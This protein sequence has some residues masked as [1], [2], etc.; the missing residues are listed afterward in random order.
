MTPQDLLAAFET[1]ADAPNGVTRLRELVLQLAVRG[2]L[3]PQD[4]TDEP[5]VALMARIAAQRTATGGRA[6]ARRPIAP[7]E[8]PFEIPATWQWVPFGEIFECRLG[9]MLDK[10][11]NRGAL[12]P[13][14]RNANVRWRGFDLSDVLTMRLTAEELPDVTVKKGDLVICEG[15]EPGRAA[16]WASEE[17]FAIQKA[18]HRARPC[19]VD[20]RYY[21]IHLRVD[22]SSGRLAE[23]F[24]GATIKHL[25]GQ[26]LDKYSVTLPPLKE[27]HRIVARVGELMGLLDRLEAARI[28][29][30]NVRRAARGAALAA[31]RDAGDVEAVEAAWGRI[32]GQVGLLI[33]DPSDVGAFR[34]AVVQLAVGGRLV[35]QDPSDSP[36]AK[37]LASIR[38]QRL[39]TGSLKADRSHDLGSLAPGEWPFALPEQWRM[40]RFEDVFL[41]VFTGPF[42]TSLKAHEY[43]VGGTPVVNP[44]NLRGGAIVPTADKCV[45]TATLQRLKSFLLADRD[46]VVARRGEMGRSA[47]VTP[48]EEGWLCGTGSLVLRPPIE[49]DPRYVSLYLGS[50]WT[51]NRLGGDSVGSTMKNLNQKILANLPF[52]LPPLAEQRRI[53]AKVAAL[54][55]LCDHLETRLTMASDLHGQFATSVVHHLEV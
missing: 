43:V 21:Q 23:L 40:V 41:E 18:L 27:Q 35:P 51:V 12:H 49:V 30:E 29:R 53:V 6:S 39:R 33:A 24:T 26:M 48:K 46:I 16:V 50:P 52:G 3:V 25:T 54:M 8:F 37:A 7:N 17:P 22:C 1:L 36:V 11:R 15:G 19:L 38:M 13:Y 20:S 47:V 10:A 44:Q 9:K 5:A 34:Q 2:R 14:L 28:T 4:R 32:A 55:A 31:L 45:G 42:G